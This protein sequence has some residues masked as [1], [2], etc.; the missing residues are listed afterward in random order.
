MGKL[1]SYELT[2]YTEAPVHIGSDK[3][4]TSKEY[5]Y[6][7]NKY[8]FPDMGEVYRVISSMGP[9]VVQEF[10]DFLLG[11]SN[12]KRDSRQRK[13]ARLIEF[14]RNH[15]IRQRD[16]AGYSLE[17]YGL[18]NK[19]KA[20]DSGSINEV[21]AFIKDGI[22]RPYVPGSSI[23]GAI[24]TILVNTYFKD[25]YP[26]DTDKRIPWGREDD[27]FSNIRVS[28]GRPLKL[29]AL[30]I[31]QKWDYS[32]RQ[33]KE[34]LNAIP[35]YREAI[36]PKVRMRFSITCEGEEAKNI[37]AN[38]GDF[39]SKQYDAYVKKFLYALPSHYTT[40]H[41]NA[42]GQYLYLG[43]GT[44]FW[45][46]TMLHDYIKPSGSRK[47]RMVGDGVHKLTKLSSNQDD[48]AEMGKCRFTI[49]EN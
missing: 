9:K 22:G 26:K 1:Y 20:E 14:L 43:A 18:V 6:E 11:E 42:N 37:I 17:G 39:A 2:L 47:M 8:Y 19:K 35:L 7:N 38:L 16:F 28:D 24:R 23:K 33:N 31:V 25:I 36:R 46:K 40:T 29:D 5:I 13:Q 41:Q 32:F 27:I 4:Y 15:N 49:E 44:G 45:T 12:Y 21:S 3:S 48:L 34:K 30:V 10:E